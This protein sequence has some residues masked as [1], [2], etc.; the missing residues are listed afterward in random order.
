MPELPEVETNVRELEPLL[1]GRQVMAVHVYW[2]GT[3]A[4]PTPEQFVQQMSG[5]RFAQFDRRGK[6]MILGLE[7]GASLIVH[8]RMTGQLFVQPADVEP[9]QH[10]HVVFDLDDDR[11]LHYQDT[12]KFGRIWLVADPAQ[13]LAKLGPEPFHEEFTAESLAQKLAGRKASI[14]AL[15]LDQTVVAGVGNIYADEA[16]FLAGIHPARGGGELQPEEIERLHGAIRTILT[17]AIQ[18]KGSSLGKSS[19]QNYMRPS[20]EPGSFQEEWAVYKRAG[21][22]CL[23][24]GTPIER[25]VLAQRSAHFCPTCQ[26]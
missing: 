14:K 12:R 19:L 4:A 23:R 10:T 18:R 25:I 26:L 21:Q 24:C 13:V 16:L 17:T 2:P 9:N 11:R 5:Q 6:Y 3:I 8:L 1:R 7:S 22:A 15:L 20:G